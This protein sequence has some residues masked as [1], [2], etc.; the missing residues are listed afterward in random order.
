MFEHSHGRGEEKAIRVPGE[1]QSRH[2]GLSRQ[3][4]TALFGSSKI[5]MVAEQSGR[6]EV[7]GEGVRGCLGQGGGTSHKVSE[8]TLS[9]LYVKWEAIHG[10]KQWNGI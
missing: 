6:R 7:V 2:K 9:T 5:T 10:F 1:E 8:A 3:E 4:Y